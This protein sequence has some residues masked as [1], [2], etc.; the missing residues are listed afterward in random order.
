MK[1]LD[2]LKLFPKAFLHLWF[3]HI[4]LHCGVD[5]IDDSM[6]LCD[7]CINKLPYCDF[8]SMEYNPIE[9]IFWGRVHLLHADSLLFF[10]KESIVQLIISELKYKHNK[11]A[12][13]MLGI[14]IGKQL[15]SQAKYASIDYIIPI[16]ITRQK[17][18]TRGYNQ[19]EIIFEGIHKIFSK[20]ILTN[21][22]FRTRQGDTQTKKDRVDR[23]FQEAIVFSIQES[24]IIQSKNIL[25]IDDVVTTGAT[26]EAACICLQSAQPSSISLFTACYT[27]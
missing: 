10:T 8:D 4:C 20:P 16:P 11:K 25:I 26:L 5:D 13:W 7:S 18:L 24:H 22:L 1:F 9:K 21:I 12:G 15:L 3:P 23:N 17:K 6:V 2:E 19:S 14:L 27:I